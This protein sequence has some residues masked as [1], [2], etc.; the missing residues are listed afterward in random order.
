M[1]CRFDEGRVYID[2]ITDSLE[3]KH[4]QLWWDG[5]PFIK[6]ILAGAA[7]M[8]LFLE[9][10]HS[11][12]LVDVSCSLSGNFACLVLNKLSGKYYAFVD[13]SRQMDLFYSKDVIATSFLDILGYVRPTRGQLQMDI[14]TEFILTGFVFSPEVFFDNIRLLQRNEI[15]VSEPGR[16]EVIQKHLPDLFSKQA[17]R[18]TFVQLFENIVNSIRSRQISIDLTGGL[19]TRLTVLLFR[20][21]GASF[22]TAVCGMANHPDVLI[23]S[24]LAANLGLDHYVTFH[25]INK[26]SLWQ[27]LQ[28][29]FQ[30]CDGLSNLLD[31]HR[32][33]QLKRDRADRGCTLAIGAS[34]GELYKD[35]GWWRTALLTGPGRNRAEVTLRKLVASGLVGWGLGKS[36][37]QGLFSHCLEAAANDYKSKLITWLKQQYMMAD[38]YKLADR[39]FYEYSVNAPRGTKHSIIDTYIPLLDREAV[40]IGVNLPHH[41][42]LL[43]RFHREMLSS[44]NPE[45]A[46]FNTTRGGMSGAD[47]LYP[48]LKDV[49]KVPLHLLHAQLKQGASTSINNPRLYSLTRQAK[50]TKNLFEILKKEKIISEKLSITDVDD[51]YLGR[52]ITIAM[53]LERIGNVRA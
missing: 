36:T 27:E 42:R 39:I 22:E 43:H 18:E 52:L 19:D 5:I 30:F 28:Q 17:D 37:P 4:Y 9:E 41:K 32:L 10:L 6:G 38:K 15:L 20:K 8:K 31:N 24:Q 51:K 35:G 2:R 26:S 21:F 53:L 14:V 33:Y 50:Q 12:E 16:Q 25:T 11:K 47:G 7:S 45:A 23:S 3:N 46:G 40:S 13:N 1:I 48:L 29:T 34:G 44:L 49:I